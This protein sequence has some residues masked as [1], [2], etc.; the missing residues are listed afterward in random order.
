MSVLITAT[1]SA[2]RPLSDA[3]WEAVERAC[4]L[5]D[6]LEETRKT[7]SCIL[8]NPV[9]LTPV[10]ADIHVRQLKNECS[11]TQPISYCWYY[12]SRQTPWCRRW[13]RSTGQNAI[14]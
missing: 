11:R 2:G 10:I 7:V 5:A 13:P 6:R 12:Y 8:L 3:R 4:D 1:T 14:V 9:S